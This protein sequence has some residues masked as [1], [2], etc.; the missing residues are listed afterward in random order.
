MNPPRLTLLGSQHD[1]LVDY[2]DGHPKGHER[3]AVVLFRRLHACVEGISDSDR[4]I[5][6]EVIFFDESWINS[7]SPAHLDFKLGPLRK[8]FRRCEEEKLVFG[9]VHN[10]PQGEKKFSMKDDENERTLI[11][12]IK[13]RNGENITFVSMLWV[14]GLWEA[15]V[16]SGKNPGNYVPVRHTLVTSQPLQIFGYQDSSHEHT[17]VYIRGEAAFGKPFVNKLQSLRVG[18]VG[19]GGTGSP[20][21]TLGARSGFGELILIDDDELEQSNLNRVRGLRRK[22]VGGKKSLKLKEYINSIGLPTKV[23]AIDAKVDEDPRALDALASCDVIF[24]CTDDFV[25]RDILNLALYAYAQ[26]LIDIGLGGR[27]LD[28]K[29]GQPIL[30]YHFG[31]ISTI[32]PEIGQCLYCQGVIRDIWVQTQLAR[33]ENPGITRE[34]LKE[35]YLEDGGEEA[36]GVGPFT[37]TTADYALSTLFD[38]IKPFRRFPKELRKDMFQVDFVKMELSSHQTKRNPECPYCEKHEFLL[39]KEEYRLQRPILGKRDDKF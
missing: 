7:S 23:A 18:I 13:N 1:S 38:L 34:E 5:G 21:A 12:A 25:G 14:N 9:F 20:L 36:P 24:G 33:R 17:E 27:I 2:L 32:S 16:R 31:R 35:R 30:R 4:Y 22:D 28:D 26:V 37:S 10:H 15:R 11:T 29:L 39:M 3:G 19:T 8:L 6:K